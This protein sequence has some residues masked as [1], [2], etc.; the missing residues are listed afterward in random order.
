MIHLT[1]CLDPMDG[2]LRVVS[3]SLQQERR[4]ADDAVHQEVVF[5]EIEHL[6]GHAERGGDT[7][8]PGFIGDTLGR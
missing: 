2:D 4:T 3:V 7:L 5:D 1:S 8:L 6:V